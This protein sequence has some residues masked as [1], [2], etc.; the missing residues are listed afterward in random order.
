MLE[1][2]RSIDLIILIMVAILLCGLISMGFL[3][4]IHRDT[5]A[6]RISLKGIHQ[7]MSDQIRAWAKG[8]KTDVE[9]W[10]QKG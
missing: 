3:W 9:D 7:L 5:K 6:Q 1:L 4:S 8:Q 2:L 10:K